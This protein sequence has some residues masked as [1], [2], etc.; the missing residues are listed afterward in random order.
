M[1]GSPG[2]VSSSRAGAVAVK[3]GGGRVVAE[4]VDHEVGRAD[5]V[6]ERDRAVGGDRELG[7]VVGDRA[8][9]RVEVARGGPG[10]AGVGG[11]EGGVGG[12]GGGDVDRDRGRPVRDRRPAADGQR[13]GRRCAD[14]AGGLVGAVGGGL[15]GSRVEQPRR[16]DRREA[17]GV[18]E[19]AEHV[20]HEVGRADVVVE[21]DRAVGRDRELGGVVRHHTGLGVQVARRRP[22]AAGVGG[23]ERRLRGARGR[24]VDRHGHHVGGMPAR[25]RIGSV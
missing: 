24:D 20:D 10:G 1:V 12:A 4:H 11:D 13:V 7:G 15:P 3:H 2:R 25:P 9:A 18:D 14:R 23:D 17:R 6:V 16:R 19:Y 22:R 8:G 5:V 21:R